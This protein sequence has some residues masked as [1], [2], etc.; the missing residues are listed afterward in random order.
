MST[1]PTLSVMD[2]AS[3]YDSQGAEHVESEPRAHQ[4]ER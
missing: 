2:V 3:I 4:R 1:S